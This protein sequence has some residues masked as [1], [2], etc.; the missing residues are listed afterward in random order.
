MSTLRNNRYD[1]VK[2]VDNYIS[3]LTPVSPNGKSSMPAPPSTPSVPQEPMFPYMEQ[4]PPPV[5]DYGYIPGYLLS[6]IGKFVRA[7]FIVG[8][9]QFMD[10]SGKLLEVGINYFVLQEFNTNNKIMCDLYSVR[11]VTFY[12]NTINM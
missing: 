3:T 4:G 6:N 10:K 9:N 1:E 12:T 7:E 5:T 2:S 11:F 8:T